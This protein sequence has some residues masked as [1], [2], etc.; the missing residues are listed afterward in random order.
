M[1]QAGRRAASDQQPVAVSNGLHSLGRHQAFAEIRKVVR[2]PGYASLRVD[3]L[4]TSGTRPCLIQ[5][6][7]VLKERIEVIYANSLEQ[8]LKHLFKGLVQQIVA[9]H[10][11]R[12]PA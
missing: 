7:H 12:G 2:Q 10:Q 5:M 4:A 9:A 3:S 1:R 11:G 6:S 8:Q